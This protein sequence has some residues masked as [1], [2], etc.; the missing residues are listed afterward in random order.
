VKANLGPVRLNVDYNMADQSVL[1][2]GLGFAIGDRAP[3]VKSEG[4]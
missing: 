1:S 4:K 3:K 2:V